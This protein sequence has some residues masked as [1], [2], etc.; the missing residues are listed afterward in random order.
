MGLHVNYP[1]FW[2][3]FNG[4]EFFLQIVEKYSK[5]QNYTKIRP[6]GTELFHTDR[7]TGIHGEVKSLFEISRTQLK[8]I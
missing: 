4:I 8:T 6:V 3:N 1:L 2:L 7:Q 5:I